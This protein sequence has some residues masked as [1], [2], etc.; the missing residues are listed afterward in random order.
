MR[1]PCHVTTLQVGIVACYE[2]GVNKD[3]K[4]VV[5][6]GM[7]NHHRNKTPWWIIALVLIMGTGWVLYRLSHAT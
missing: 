5:G 2:R 7:M 1:R 6:G 3:D 4:P